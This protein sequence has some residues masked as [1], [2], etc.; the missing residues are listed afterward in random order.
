MQ[1]S[2]TDQLWFATRIAKGISGWAK[3]ELAV[4]YYKLAAK[5][6]ATAAQRCIRAC[7]DESKLRAANRAQ[8]ETSD[9][10]HGNRNSSSSAAEGKFPRTGRMIG[11]M[12]ASGN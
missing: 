4:T 12:Y 2:A 3:Q 1:K 7:L 8:A 6:G 11:D 10:D 9:P 5:T